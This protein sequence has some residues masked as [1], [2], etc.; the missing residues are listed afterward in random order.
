M[1]KPAKSAGRVRA[2]DQA[3]IDLLW[4]ET[5]GAY[6][7]QLSAYYA[8]SELWDDGIIDPVDTRNALAIAMSAAMNA[9]LDVSGNGVFRF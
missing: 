3:E 2:V 1:S 5:R 6:E 9:P 4:R 7:D 8:T